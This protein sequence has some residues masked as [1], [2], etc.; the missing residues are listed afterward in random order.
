MRNIL[1]VVAMIW[2]VC[3]MAQD[4]TNIWKGTL[5]AGVQTL[6]IVLHVDKGR[7]TVTMDVVEQGAGSIPMQVNV[8]TD[9]SLNVN[10]S[11]LGINYVGRLKDGKILGRFQQMVFAAP[12]NLEPGAVT[13][14]RPQEPRP[15][16][17]YDMRE[18]SFVNEDAKVVLAG[19]LTYPVNYKKG[20]RVP[21][22]LM[23]T[24]SGAQDR[25]EEILHHKPFW[26]IADRLAQHGIATLRYDDRGT[27]QSTGDFRTATTK[28][29]ADDARCGL[30]F[31]R[32]QKEFSKVGIM[33][34]SE[35]GMIAY[36]LGSEHAPDFIVSLAG[37]ACRID[38]M[39]MM[40]FNALAGVQGAVGNVV[41]S[42]EE[43]RQLMLR[44]QDTPWARYFL[45][46]DMAPYVR[47][48][49]CPVLALGGESDLNV[50]VSLNTPA[51]ETC[52]SK[53]RNATIKVY[54]GLS[55]MFQHNATG[56]PAKI[57]HIEET[58]A[59]EVLVDMARWINGLMK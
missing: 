22:V 55:H 35:G 6:T 21:V 15:K 45:D 38:T 20:K 51:L 12:L 47:A 17:P 1:V 32:R 31:L 9:D 53:N 28:D 44:Q 14:F 30:A 27:A 26:V 33:G 39:M 46:L 49:T 10:F 8:L 34:H 42:V 13:F 16:Y 40:Q 25:N 41:G 18:V 4:M 52:L 48:T 37:P 24:G 56:D 57:V 59:P 5:K 23:V 50:P 54:P 3:A 29:F 36:M 19:T 43:A 11:Q 2:S 7:Q 58:I